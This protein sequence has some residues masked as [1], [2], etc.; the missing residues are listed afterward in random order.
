MATPTAQRDAPRVSVVL[1]T[2][3]RPQHVPACVASILACAGRFELLVVDQSADPATGDALKPYT[4]DPRLRYVRSADVGVSTARNTGIGLATG[5]LIAFTDDDCRVAPDWIERL[6]RAFQG[7]PDTAIVCGRVRLPEGWSQV[8]YAAGFEPRRRVYKGSLPP[9]EYDWGIS[10]NMT[11][12]RDVFEQLGAF[13][14]LLGAG[15]PMRSGAETDLLYRAWRAGL[16]VVNAAEV[17]VLHL[18]IRRHGAEARAL[19]RGYAIGTGAV[20]VKHARLRDGVA[21]R[22]YFRWLWPA[23]ARNVHSLVRLERHTGLVFTL[24]FL[25]SVAISFR[26]QVDRRTGM[27]ARRA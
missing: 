11:V 7:T 12:R 20:F 27:Y 24:G 16:T 6:E 8:G 23:L 5:A 1:P 4:A 21:L 18:G 2:R 22:L 26:Y 10:A 15:A 3:D 19:W 25:S 14:V 17:E 9:P 13:D